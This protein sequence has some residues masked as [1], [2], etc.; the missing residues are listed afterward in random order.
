MRDL[1]FVLVLPFILF[2]AWRRPFIALGLNLWTALIFPN[3][4]MYGFATSIRVNLI[5]AFIMFVTYARLER[6][7]RFKFDS[8]MLMVTCFAIWFTMTSMF[9]IHDADI[10]WDYWFRVIKVLVPAYFAILIIEKKIHFDF[11]A[12]CIVFSIGF[13]AVVEGLKWVASGGG[14]AIEGLHSHSLQDRNELSIAFSMTIPVAL[15]LR[16]QYGAKSKIVSLG[17]L[18]VVLL[19]VLSILGTN[20]RGGFVSMMALALYLFKKSKHKVPLLIAAAIAT[21]VAMQFLSD[22]WFDRM[23]TIQKA[24]D[25]SSFMARM[26][27]WKQSVI[28]VS[29]RPIFGGGFKAIENTV[30]WNLMATRWDEF[31]WFNTGDQR[32]GPVARAAHSVYFQLM[33]DHGIVGLGIYLIIIALCFLKNNRVIKQGKKINAPSWMIDAAVMLQLSLFVFC[34]GGLTL[35]F[36]YFDMT[37]MLFALSAVLHGIL[38][39]KYEAAHKLQG[40]FGAGRNK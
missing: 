1:V 31:S 5:L 19:L 23:N 10:V 40:K 33:G 16:G 30:N 29:E 39:S 26:V 22:K 20:S 32:P 6:K 11:I 3:G 28:L 12:W 27:A 4:W 13:F 14:H 24:D 18:G 7:Q 35:S 8:I 9:P 38:F 2:A 25:D 15:Y 21:A 17:L 34:V 37:Y 36:A